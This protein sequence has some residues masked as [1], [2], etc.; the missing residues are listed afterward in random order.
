ML[1]EKLSLGAAK[2]TTNVWSMVNL[3]EETTVCSWPIAEVWPNAPPKLPVKM[4]CPAAYGSTFQLHIG[5]EKP[6]RWPQ[7]A[8]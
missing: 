8:S 1:F 7:H 6:S 2:L 3:K 4:G 5:G